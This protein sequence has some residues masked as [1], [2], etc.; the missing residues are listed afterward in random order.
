MKNSHEIRVRIEALARELANESGKIPNAEFGSPFEAVEVLAA[1]L[2]DSSMREFV[3][4]QHRIETQD[5]PAEPN[6]CCPDC[7]ATGTLKKLCLSGKPPPA[8]ASND[9]RRC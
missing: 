3:R 7:G 6:S 4:Q 5:P 2:G 1:E 8:I 9:S